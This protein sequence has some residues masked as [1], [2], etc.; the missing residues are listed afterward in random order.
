MRTRITEFFG[1]R[2]PI[3]QGGLMWVARAEL[4]SAVAN[5]GAMGFLTALTHA[6][7]EGL[8]EEIKKTRAL[9]DRPFGVN[10]TFLPTL[11]SPNYEGYIDVALEAFGPERLMYGSDWP[12]CRLAAEYGP[13]KAIVDDRL[14]ALSSE[15]QAAIFGATATRVYALG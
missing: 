11:R 15:E 1:V 4:V 7:T 12:V 2:H 3:V 10:L 14:A 8:R 6:E 13:M 5:A 9:T